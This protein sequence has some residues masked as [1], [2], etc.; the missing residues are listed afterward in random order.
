MD[1]SPIE[2]D[3]LLK[4]FAQVLF[5]NDMDA[6]NNVVA[7]DFSEAFM[8]ASRGRNRWL[9]LPLS[10]NI[11]LSTR[12]CSPRN[13]RASNSAARHHLRIK[14]AIVLPFFSV[15]LQLAERLKTSRGS[16]NLLP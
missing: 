6:L 10:A 7:P 5:K 11:W 13:V 1:P 9:A 16:R 4:A 12:R 2:R 3:R 8:T 15:S 14:A